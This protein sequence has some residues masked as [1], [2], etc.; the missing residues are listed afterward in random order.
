MK[1]WLGPER[2]S[3]GPGSDLCIS[4]DEMQLISMLKWDED[5]HIPGSHSGQVTPW[6]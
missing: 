1:Q 4:L 3:P 6:I 5:T 2:P